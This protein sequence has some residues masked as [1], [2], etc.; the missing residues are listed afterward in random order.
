M[1]SFLVRPIMTGLLALI[2]AGFCGLPQGRYGVAPVSVTAC[3]AASA[4][5]PMGLAARRAGRC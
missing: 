3:H 1:Q 2:I 4:I 5:Q